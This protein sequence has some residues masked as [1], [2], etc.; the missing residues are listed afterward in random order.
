[1]LPEHTPLEVSQFPALD[2]DKSANEFLRIE[3]KLSDE[4]YWTLLRWV[5]I[6]HGGSVSRL[7]AQHRLLM[8][9]RPSKEFLMTENERKEFEALP[10]EVIVYHGTS[11]KAD[12]FGWCWSRQFDISKGFARNRFQDGPRVIV[13][14]CKKSD[15]VAY[16]PDY[17]EDEIVI[18][19]A[20]VKIDLDLARDDLF[21]YQPD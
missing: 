6:Y 20:H 14:R 16:F 5:W 8:A 13:G 2:S 3:S 18:D 15:A 11:L 17:D 10:D 4:Q 1:M 21:D 7:Q 12:E 19:P 9:D